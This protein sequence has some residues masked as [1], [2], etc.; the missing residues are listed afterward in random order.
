MEKNC[1]CVLQVLNIFHQ[2]RHP[3]DNKIAAES[4]KSGMNLVVNFLSFPNISSKIRLH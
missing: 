2:I 1:F 3:A 4:Y